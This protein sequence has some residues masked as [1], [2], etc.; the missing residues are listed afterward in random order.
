MGEIDA[1]REAG[2]IGEAD[3]LLARVV[4]QFPNDHWAM[5]Q[6]GLIALQRHDRVASLA[7]MDALRA[8][9]GFADVK[10][11]PPI[12]GTIISRDPLIVHAA[13]YSIDAVVRPVMELYGDVRSPVHF[14]FN[15]NMSLVFHHELRRTIPAEISRLTAEFPSVRITFLANDV[16]ELLVAREE[17][18]M[19]AE[20]VSNNAFV[21]ERLYVIRPSVRKQFDAIYNARFLPYKRFHLA[22]RVPNLCVVA[23][24]IT[25][26]Q[27]GELVTMISGAMVN[28]RHLSGGDVVDLVNASRC[29]LCL[30]GAEGAMYASIESLLCGVPIVT[31]RSIGGRDWFFMDDYVIYAED[32]PES[33]AESVE[34]MAKRELRPEFIR[35]IAIERLERERRMFFALVDRVFAESGQENRR[36]EPEFRALFHDKMNYQD[37]KLSEFLFEP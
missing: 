3:R 6:Y 35:Q 21:D 24:A 7:R 32:T 37:R 26:A 16:R 36:F 25:A 4:E 27:R 14:F 8:M 19:N 34:R 9:P 23:A 33:V 28:E 1:L 30:S 12:V 13:S 15:S 17:C 22:A 29:S 20:L 2:N 11:G 10:V 5:T 31:T 18:H